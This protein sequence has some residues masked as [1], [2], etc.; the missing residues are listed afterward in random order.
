MTTSYNYIILI[1]RSINQDVQ[2]LY[3]GIAHEYN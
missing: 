3:M 2:S 1:H